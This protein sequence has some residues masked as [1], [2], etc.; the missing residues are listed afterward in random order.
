[1][2]LAAIAREAVRA[3]PRPVEAPEP[4]PEA[5]AELLGLYTDPE[6]TDVLRLEWRDGALIW[7]LQ[8]EP[9]WRPTLRPTADPDAFTVEPGV[10]Q[11]GELCIFRR[12]DDGTVTG[13]KLGPMELRRLA[14]VE[15]GG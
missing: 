8:E 2:D 15:G 1:M 5:Y 3:A 7:V 11:S 9:E 6:W 4:L 13:A 14:P 10:R 12:R